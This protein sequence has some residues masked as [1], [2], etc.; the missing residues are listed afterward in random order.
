MVRRVRKAPK[1]GKDGHSA[2]SDTKKN[3]L[4][5][6]SGAPNNSLGSEGDF[7]IDLLNK[8]L[9][10]PKTN[11]G[12]SDQFIS[13]GASPSQNYDYELVYEKNEGDRFEGEVLKQWLSIR[14]R[15]INMNEDEDLR[16]VKKIATDVFKN[17]SRLESIVIGENVEIIEARAFQNL[18]SLKRVILSQKIKGI[19]PH[20]FSNTGL[21]S[22]TLPESITQIDQGA[23]ADCEDLET[24]IIEAKTPPKITSVKGVDRAIF[25]NDRKLK[26]IYVPASSIWEYK[27]TKGWEAYEHLIEG[28]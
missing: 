8:R 13:L 12:W 7:Y 1:K 22:I 16:K 28:K 5:S 14:I 26:H 4:F 3:S 2:P 19:H 6:G 27:G 10:G 11:R 18:K 23:F 15:H 24:V 17:C 9:Y 21:V 20:T 25:E